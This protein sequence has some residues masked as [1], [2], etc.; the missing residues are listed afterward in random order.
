MGA[1][2]L[3]LRLPR[4]RQ[5]P[6]NGQAHRTLSSQAPEEHLGLRY[7]TSEGLLREKQAC[8]TSKA[9]ALLANVTLI[10]FELGHT[11][12]AGAKGKGESCSCVRRTGNSRHGSFRAHTPGSLPAAAVC[13]GSPCTGASAAWCMAQPSR[14]TGTMVVPRLSLDQLHKILWSQ[15]QTWVLS[16]ALFGI[17]K[18]SLA[19]S[20]VQHGQGWKSAFSL[21]CQT[22]GQRHHS[23][24]QT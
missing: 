23:V 5:L 6:G 22:Q 8:R 4:G 13:S 19:D 20:A 10:Y 12:P 21:N 16:K 7:L 17:P 24:Q 3:L 11:L 14:S 18:G 2:V 9:M 15:V 1:L